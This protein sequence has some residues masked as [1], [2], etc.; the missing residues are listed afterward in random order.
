MR[1]VPARGSTGSGI[2]RVSSNSSSGSQNRDSGF[3]KTF[4]KELEKGA[5]SLA[6]AAE[7]RVIR[8]AVK[9]VDEEIDEAFA[10]L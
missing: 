3:W 4:G 1:K 2:S 6:V 8:D 10:D 5:I 7:K 9:A